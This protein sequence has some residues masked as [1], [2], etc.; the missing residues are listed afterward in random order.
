MST[1]PLP[2]LPQVRSRAVRHGRVVGLPK[3]LPLH[4]TAV[5]STAASNAAEDQG[6]RAD[7]PTLAGTVTLPSLP[8]VCTNKSFLSF[9][10]FPPPQY[11]SRCQRVRKRALTNW[12][13]FLGPSEEKRATAHRCFGSCGGD[14][15][16]IPC[17]R[18]F[19]VRVSIVFVRVKRRPTM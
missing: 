19:V 6:L 7:R 1:P 2:D 17:W 13:W 9:A 3:R 5:P 18:L 12:L 16:V 15:Y 8:R 10:P 11:C 4:P 14:R